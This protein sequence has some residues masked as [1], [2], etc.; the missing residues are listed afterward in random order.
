MEITLNEHSSKKLFV[1]NLS[2]AH[3]GLTSMYEAELGHQICN[4]TE[5]MGW[6]GWASLARLGF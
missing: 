5:T 6:A 2:L 1:K 3:P 4:P